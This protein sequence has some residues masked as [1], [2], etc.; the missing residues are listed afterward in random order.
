M[1]IVMIDDAANSYDITIGAGGAGGALSSFGG[2]GGP[3]ILDDGT[4]Q[5]I[6][7]G[8][9]AGTPLFDQYN[10][11]T[12]TNDQFG[13]SGA[14]GAA[15]SIAEMRSNG[16]GNKVAIEQTKRG[17]GGGVP[18]YGMGGYTGALGFADVGQAGED[19]KVIIEY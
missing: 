2:D 9:S 4:T 13:Y 6:G 19:G 3:T 18:G 1:C 10:G 12:N 5:Y 16:L 11:G 15:R 8:G 7:G 14:T 17:Y